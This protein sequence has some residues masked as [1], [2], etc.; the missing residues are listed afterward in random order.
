MLTI[1]HDTSRIPR[2]TVAQRTKARIRNAE[3]AVRREL[4]SVPLFP[5]LARF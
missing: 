2:A 4:D 3:R 1:R 5:E